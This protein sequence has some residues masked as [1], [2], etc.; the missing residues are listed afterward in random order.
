M[1]NSSS[2]L[3][4]ITNPGAFLSE[5]DILKLFPDEPKSH[6]IGF[7]EFEKMEKEAEK[8]AF[9]W[10]E[11]VE[12]M[13]CYPFFEIGK[14]KITCRYD[15]DNKCPKWSMEIAGRSFTIENFVAL[16]IAVE[17]GNPKVVLNLRSCLLE[18]DLKDIKIGE[19]KK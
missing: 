5:K 9:K 1:Y 14:H 17:L 4:K 12:E 11:S 10:K 7:E 2:T 15:Y 6:N 19:Y 8:Y 13:T 18:V 3:A 16:Q